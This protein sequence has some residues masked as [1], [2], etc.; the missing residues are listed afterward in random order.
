MPWVVWDVVR[1][2]HRSGSN[3][4][5]VITLTQNNEDSITFMHRVCLWVWGPLWK[6][7]AVMVYCDNQAVGT[8]RYNR[9]LLLCNIAMFLIIG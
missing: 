9:L 2:G 5:G 4:S 7:S 6:N 1:F 3:T 8:G